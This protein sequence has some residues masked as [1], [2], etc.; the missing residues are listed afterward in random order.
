MALHFLGE[1]D[2]AA[3]RDRVV[4][5]SID[6]SLDHMQRFDPRV[7]KVE[8]NGVP[9]GAAGQV[10]IVHAATKGVRTSFTITTVESVLPEL[11]VERVTGDGP[12]QL[13]RTTFAE[14]PDG[15]TRLSFDMTVTVP[16]W[17]PMR[18]LY[19]LV[20][21]RTIRSTLARIKEFVE[22]GE[23]TTRGTEP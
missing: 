2:V 4:A 21:P 10:V 18:P 19:R 12:D 5:S 15:G 14:L 16:W 23:P 3:P 17:S 9:D 22:T 13:I 6:T 11:V 8:T 1:V 20:L 7:E